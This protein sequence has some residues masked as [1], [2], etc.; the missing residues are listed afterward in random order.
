MIVPQSDIINRIQAAIEALRK[1]SSNNSATT[2]LVRSPLSVG[3]SPEEIYA[4]VSFL[5]HERRQEWVRYVVESRLRA[6]GAELAQAGAFAHPEEI[7]QSGDVPGEDGWRYYFHG[8]GCC[9]SHTDGTAVD[10]DFADDGS[11]LDIDPYFYTS[12]LGSSA[13]LGFC[14][15]QLKQPKGLENGWQVVLPRLGQAGMIQMKWRF[16]LSEAGRATASALE[17][18]LDFIET[19]SGAVRCAAFSLIGDYVNAEAEAVRG[20]LNS[21][22]FSASAKRQLSDRV[23]A[24]RVVIRGKDKSTARFALASLAAIGKVHAL[25]DVLD[26]LRRKP[27]G[28]LNHDAL[29]ALRLW[30]GADVTH[31]LV[32]ALRLFTGQSFAERLRQM[33]SP[34]AFASQNERA[35]NGIITGIAAALFAKLTPQ[36]LKAEAG[37]DLSRAMRRDC[38]A[39]DDDA[40][41][42]LYLLDATAGLAK[43]RANLVNPV[44]ITRQGAACFLALIGTRTSEEILIHAARGNVEDGGHEAACALSLLQSEAAQAAALEWLRRNDEFEDAEGTEIDFNGKKVRTW[45]ADEMMRST[46]REDIRYW[47]DKKRTEFAPLLQLWRSQLTQQ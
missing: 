45:S 30:E 46:L 1:D 36:A 11:A 20:G 28:G 6:N 47:F 15:A 23:A 33:V 26:A 37:A 8:R 14:E 31:A 29:A 44:P 21:A 42:F 38:Q 7:A 24:M 40:G 18:L 32:K 4:L 16:R 25:D 35:T 10:V 19:H 34:A 22:E 12:Y 17:P 41:F 27:A 13:S 9:F 43:L 3:L 5:R 2:G 39:C